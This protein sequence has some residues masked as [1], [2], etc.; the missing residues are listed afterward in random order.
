MVDGDDIDNDLLLGLLIAAI[1]APVA[2]PVDRETVL[3]LLFVVVICCCCFGGVATL[4]IAGCVVVC[5][6]DDTADVGGGAADDDN[7]GGFTVFVIPH[8]RDSVVLTTLR[9]GLL[10]LHIFALISGD[11]FVVA[12]NELLLL[13]PATVGRVD[14]DAGGSSFANTSTLQQLTQMS[15]VTR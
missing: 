5:G 9:L 8:I 4:A 11:I 3:L 13:L 1:A 15:I 7:K 6:G 12:L 10:G 2:L 14:D